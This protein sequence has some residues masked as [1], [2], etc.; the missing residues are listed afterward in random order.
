MGNANSG[1]R[2]APTAL[3]MLRGNPSKTPFNKNEPKPER[4][5]ASFDIPPAEL[6]GDA[7]AC[8]EWARVAP[9]VRVCG[10]ISKAESGVLLVLC[11]QWSRYLEAHAKVQQLGMIVKK[12]SGV[13][14][15]N[16]YM[17]VSDRALAQCLKLWQELGL[18]PSS[19][20]RL[21]AIPAGDM[22]E[23]SKWEGLL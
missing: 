5:T 8:A 2:P 11:Q 12:P 19:R 13:P 23:L 18:T 4:P 3:K 22:P 17:S 6:A 15:I 1:R 10:L 7:L 9:I 20:S 14:M 21:S 16:P